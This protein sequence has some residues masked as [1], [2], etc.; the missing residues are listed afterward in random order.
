ME[1]EQVFEGTWDETEEVDGQ[2]R[3]RQYYAT[4]D[5]VKSVANRL[6]RLKIKAEIH[7]TLNPRNSVLDVVLV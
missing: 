3:Y 5:E 7:V 6:R 2:I 1:L 4:E